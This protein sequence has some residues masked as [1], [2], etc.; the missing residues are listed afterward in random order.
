MKEEF[1]YTLR[2]GDG[3]ESSAA[4][5][6]CVEDTYPTVPQDGNL[7]LTVDED[8]LPAGIGNDFPVGSPNDAPGN[9]ASAIGNIPFT[10]GADPVTIEL[11]VGNG[12]DTGLRPWTAR[13][14]SRPGI[15]RPAR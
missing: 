9:S 15:R 12:G 14:C 10:P 8:G 2:D 7:C 5:K 3:D 13:T 6:I 1:G 4:L 11:S